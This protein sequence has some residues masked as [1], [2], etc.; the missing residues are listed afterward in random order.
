MKFQNYSIM[1]RWVFM[2]LVCLWLNGCGEFNSSDDYHEDEFNTSEIT[3]LSTVFDK[4]YKHFV[5]NIKIREDLLRAEDI[6]DSVITVE[7]NVNKEAYE[8]EFQPKVME[9]RNIK[10]QE[11]ADMNMNVL[12][13]VDLTLDEERIKAQKRALTQLRKLFS[14]DNLYVAFMGTQSITESMLVTDYVL[15]KYFV[16]QKANKLLYRSVFSKLDEL[17]GEFHIPHYF[18]EIEH[19]KR[20]EALSY[21]QKAL[22]IFSDETVYEDNTPIDSDHYDLQR[23]LINVKTADNHGAVYYVNFED[24]DSKRGVSSESRNIMKV[25]CKNTNGE[26]FDKFHIRDITNSLLKMLVKMPADFQLVFTNPDGKVYRGAIEFMQIECYAKEKLLAKGFASYSIGSLYNPVVINGKSTIRILLFGL[27]DSVVILIILYLIFQ[28]VVPFIRYLIFKKKS[29]T[30]YESQGMSLNGV[31]VEQSCYYCKAPFKKGDEIVAKCSHTLH[32]SC[33]D[34]NEYKCP[35]HGTKCEK[36]SHFYNQK[37]L[38][39]RRNAPFYLKW[40]IAGVLAGLIAWVSFTILAS[41]DQHRFLTLLVLMI[42]DVS[43]DSPNAKDILDNYGGHVFNLPFYGMNL[44]FYLCLFLSIQASHGRWLWKRLVLVGIKTLIGGFLG[45]ACF[46]I[47]GIISIVLGFTENSFLIDW[48][49]WTIMGLGIAYIVSYGTDVKLKKAMVGAVISIIFGLGSMY[50]WSYANT[51]QVDTRE[52]SLWS[53]MLYS[54]GLAFTIA[55]TSP[56]SARYF[57]RVEGPIKTMD[58]AVFKW[59]TTSVCNRRVSIGKS[60]NCNLQMTWDMN[61]SISPKQ[62]DLIMERGNIYLVAMEEGVTIDNT[63]L[64]IGAKVRLYHGNKF[65]IGQTIFTYIEKD[66]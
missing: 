36:G 40:L 7:L 38:L 3:V 1:M 21:R 33:W 24:V 44:S 27:L 9:V 15:S 49:P 25:L 61:S 53:Y 37:K 30:K 46:M 43:V 52:L 62:A 12:V 50:L 26:Y 47:G 66:I 32:R 59:L 28:F 41:R 13:L 63:Q 10:A 29:V 4:H 48:I 35:E 65:R 60:V 14:Y 5:I 57:L 2:S 31:M 39:D 8:T 55:A 58:I 18:P 6:V 45:Y 42:N 23:N 19:D 56:K 11:I 22:I 16:H 34:E 20:W 51:S 17:N 64:S 54:V